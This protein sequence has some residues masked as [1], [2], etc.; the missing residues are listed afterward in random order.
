MTLDEESEERKR[1]GGDE[2]RDKGHGRGQR[3]KES[4]QEGEMKRRTGRCRRGK[5]GEQDHRGGKRTGGGRGGGGEGRG[6]GG[7]GRG[8]R[9]TK[10]QV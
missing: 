2:R 9:K 5:K 1:G 4:C 7:G 6:G 3:E 8:D 10:R